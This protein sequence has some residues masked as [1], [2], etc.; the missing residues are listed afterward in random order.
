MKTLRG[1]LTAWFIGL[2]TVIGIV[3]SIGTGLVSLNEEN[4][5]LDDQLRQIAL[6]VGDTPSAAGESSQIISGANP[7]DHIIVHILDN[8]LK[9]IRNSDPAIDI[10]VETATG[11]Y[12]HVN[13]GVQ[14]RTFTLI[15]EN[16]V[17]QVSQQTELRT[18]A[19]FSSMLNT[20]LPI[21][22]LIPMSWIFVG[23]VVKRLLKPLQNLTAA[24]LARRTA[25]DV[26]LSSKGIPDE[27]APLVDAMNNLL[28]RQHE[29]LE[30]RQRFISDAAHQLRTPLTAL[31]LQ[32]ENLKAALS[33]QSDA[34]SL[35]PMQEGLGRMSALLGQLLKLARA[36]EPHAPANL[37]LVNLG[38]IVRASLADAH[39]LAAAKSI[40]LGLTADAN[41]KVKGES[42]DLIMLLGNLLDNAIRYTPNGGKVDVEILAAEKDAQVNIRDTGPGIPENALPLVF[43]R[44]YRHNPSRSDG[45]G[46]GLSIVAA[47][48]ARNEAVVS[49]QNRDDRQGLIANVRFT[50]G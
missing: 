19:A 27:L 30:F 6:S 34:A 40:D 16:R 45:S 43:N 46:L 22:L 23:W 37:E 25:S 36:E 39:E 1:Q 3:G 50:R 14:W 38:E 18:E 8:N 13:A 5:F 31:N 44:F 4:G 2:I 26:V 7:E 17:V 47:L 20:I 29:L 21:A 15:A 24:L 32:M 28:V 10:P 12:D 35:R 48:T 42:I 33:G 41:I 9:T 49:L 11:F